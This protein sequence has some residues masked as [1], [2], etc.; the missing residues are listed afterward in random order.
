M[1]EIQ[2]DELHER[3]R[4]RDGELVVVDIRNEAEYED[5]RIPGS[6]NIAVYDELQNDSETAAAALSAIPEDREVVTVCT[7]GVLSRKATELLRKMGYDA[8]TLVDGMEGWSRVHESRPVDVAVDGTL[9]QV[10]RPGKGCLSHVL[11]SRGEAAVYDPSQYTEEYNAILEEY[12][13]ELVGVFDTHA[14]ADHVSGGPWLADG[15]GVPY[16]LHPADAENLDV[17]PLEDGSTFEVGAVEVTTIH[18]PGHS[19]GG[20]TFAVE[21]EILLTGDTLFH[22]SVGRVELG[23]EAGLEETDVES[24]AETL[25]ESLQRL[26]QR[27]GGPLVLPAHAPGSPQP[28]VAARLSEVS[29]IND[30]LDR[31]RSA[32]VEELSSDI[33][34]HPPNFQR[35][36][37]VNTGIERVADEEL[38]DLESGPN[39]CAAD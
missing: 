27:D 5:W 20:V 15:H 9:V 26:Q 37:R 24:N 32:F 11:V 33:P 21:D 36:K 25:Y 14:H 10:A 7:A 12:D 34:E 35:V 1:M 17:A 19:P 23:V 2:P 6:E 39:R 38:P 30:D 8:K 18:T 13:A 31:E 29:R 16:H 28:P 22:D 3:L 4:A